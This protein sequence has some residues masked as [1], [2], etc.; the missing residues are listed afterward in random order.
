M[1]YNRDAGGRADGFNVVQSILVVL[2]FRSQKRQKDISGETAARDSSSE[3]M[4]V[5]N[6]ANGRNSAGKRRKN[7]AKRPQ[8]F[9]GLAQEEKFIMAAALE[10]FCLL[11]SA[12]MQNVVR[13]KEESPEGNFSINPRGLL[14]PGPH[15]RSL[16]PAE[17]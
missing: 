16:L 11:R 6:D 7:S 3:L 12:E 2:Q 4:M 15:Q 13:Q 8:G 1:K 9:D 17:R 5:E 10:A 14:M